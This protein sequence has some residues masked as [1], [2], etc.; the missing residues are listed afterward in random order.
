MD[1]CCQRDQ[2][3]NDRSHVMPREK[4]PY[5]IDGH[6]QH[7]PSEEAPD[8]DHPLTGTRKFAQITR[9]QGQDEQG[10]P[11]TDTQGKENEERIQRIALLGDHGQKPDNKWSYAGSGNDAECE[12]HEQRLRI[13]GVGLGQDGIQGPRKTEFQNPKKLSAISSRTDETKVRTA[14]C[15][16]IE[17]MSWPVNAA[18]TPRAEFIAERPRI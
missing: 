1:A 11:E 8:P 5:K 13:A 10:Q 2:C 4:G 18:E 14:G 7:D 3:Q 15:W 16:S 9:K 12:P 17:P 6:G